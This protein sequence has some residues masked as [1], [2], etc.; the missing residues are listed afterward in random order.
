MK[1]FFTTFF[2]CLLIVPSLW[3]QNSYSDFERGLSLSDPQRAQV[4]VIRNKYINEWQ[5]LR[6]ESARKKMELRELN[7]NP[8]PNS[9]RINRL[10]G[11]LQE[12]DTARHNSYQQYRSEVSQTLN[13]KQRERYN[14]FCNQE[15]KKNPMHRGFGPGWHGR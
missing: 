4:E 10:H 7:R 3:A 2:L 9:S 5:A 13:E 14:S 6:R 15:R 8:S 11:E 12:L 1:V